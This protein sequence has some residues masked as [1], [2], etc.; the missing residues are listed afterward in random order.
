MARGSQL[1]LALDDVRVRIPWA[2]RS[3]RDLTRASSSVIFKAR[4]EKSVSDFVDADQVDL[5]PTGKK[6]PW[7]YQGAPLLKEV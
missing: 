3:P 4:A 2:G 6:A 5:W 7:V 1:A